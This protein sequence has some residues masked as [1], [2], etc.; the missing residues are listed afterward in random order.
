MDVGDDPRTRWRL[1]PLLDAISNPS[2]HALAELVMVWILPIAG[3]Y[4]GAPR[5]AVSLAD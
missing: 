1:A 5:E 4:A 3:N 2:L